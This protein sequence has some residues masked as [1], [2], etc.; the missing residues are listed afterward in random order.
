MGF[1]LARYREQ[2]PPS[3]EWHVEGGKVQVLD[4]FQSNLVLVQ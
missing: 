1:L 2:A 3:A 4:D